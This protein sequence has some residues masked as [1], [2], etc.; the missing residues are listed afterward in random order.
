MK[1]S[2]RRWPLRLGLLCLAAT[3]FFIGVV[4]LAGPLL[5][6]LPSVRSEVANKLSQANNGRI[7]W[8][9]LQVRLLPVPRVELRG[10]TVD[11]PGRVRASV[12][13]V[14][15]RLRLL[16]LLHGQVKFTSVA[17]LRP[18]VRVDLAPSAVA[19]NAAP[20]DPLA[21]YRALVEPLARTARDIAPGAVLE[22]SDSDVQV[23][24]AALPPV[25]LRGL[26]LRAQTDQSGL[27]LQANAASNLWDRVN[28]GGRI[29]FADLSAN[30]RVD[31]GGLQPQTWLDQ[32]LAG[33]SVHIDAPRAD[34]RARLATDA[35]TELRMDFDVN[36]APIDIMHAERRLHVCDC[37]VKGAAVVRA[38]EAQVVLSELRLGSLLP[39]GTAEVHMTSNAENPRVA[40]RIPML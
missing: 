22:I 25:Q 9:S 23:N 36:V 20:A 18:V 6:D 39:D 21:T 34:L 19:R 15:A 30:F 7:T 31:I 32:L 29:E 2:G 26:S 11:I 12:Q 35:R 13:Q 40:L 5:L 1:A 14:Q 3:A 10:V 8:D 24:A 28:L 37:L 33:S 4:L 27:D 16:A 17:V 38:Q